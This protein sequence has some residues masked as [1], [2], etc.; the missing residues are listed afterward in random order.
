MRN[1]FL[2]FDRLERLFKG[3]E[4]LISININSVNGE[5]DEF[6]KA[7]EVLTKASKIEPKHEGILYNLGN[8]YKGMGEY[9]K[10]ADCYEAATKINS[11]IQKH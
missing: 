5:H 7:I 10:A 6:K 11:K 4:R 2:N 1:I 9:D 3:I 8:A